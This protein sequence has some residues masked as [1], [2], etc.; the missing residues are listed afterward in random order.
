MLVARRMVQDVALQTKGANCTASSSE[1]GYH[2][3]GTING[4]Y[5]SE[6]ECNWASNNESNRAWI[7]VCLKRQYYIVGVKLTTR[8]KFCKAGEHVNLAGVRF[9]DGHYQEVSYNF[10]EII[11]I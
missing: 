3:N 2:C 8:A 1:S 11:M 4:K 5:C 9:S 6:S 7:Q 10:D